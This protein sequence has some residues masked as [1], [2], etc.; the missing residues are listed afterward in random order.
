MKTVSS[1]VADVK[2]FGV[3]AV[4]FAA[5]VSA[6]EAQDVSAI[7]NRVEETGTA[8]GTAAWTL[9]ALVGFVTSGVGVF[10]V[11]KA[12]ENREGIGMG[13]GMAIG[14]AVMTAL[15][16]LIGAFSQTG[17][18]EDASGLDRIGVE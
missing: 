6:S 16:F 8:L 13:L 9:L 12:K 7:A 5:L 4:A 1:V 11:I 2:K 10:K 14:G 3:G 15:P 18:A 17:F